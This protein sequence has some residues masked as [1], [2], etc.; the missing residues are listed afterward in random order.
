MKRFYLKTLKIIIFIFLV[1]LIDQCLGFIL[2]KLYFR[3]QTG[4]NYALNYVFNDCK[5]DILILGAS[6]AQHNYD[7]RIIC[8]SLKLSCYNAGQDGGHSILLQYAQLKVLTKRYSPKIVILEFRA[9]KMEYY[10][11]DYEKLQVLLPYY[12]KYPELS[13]LILL[14]SPI[15]RLKLLSAIYPFNSNLIN[16]IRFN[17]NNHASRKRDFNGYV[18]IKGVMKNKMTE[19]E[20]E[21]KQQLTLDT[22]KI[23]ALKK[24]ISLCKEKNIFLLIIT[25]PH[26]HKFNEKQ[27]FPSPAT[28]IAYNIIH[29]YKVNYLDFT[30]DSTYA[31]K[32]NWFK[33]NIHLNENGANYFSHI[34]A[35]KLKKMYLEKK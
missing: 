1:I 32:M 25:S 27:E 13:S 19:N 20:N 30:F 5:E 15:E 7:S 16:I 8:D 3:Q 11:E 24:I 23:N 14:R 35:G 10:K 4:Q 12:T 31:D 17:T 29:Q 21:K 33:D 26:F 9:D 18:P 6:Q 34:L 22:N 28:E 2:K